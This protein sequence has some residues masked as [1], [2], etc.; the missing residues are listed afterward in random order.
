MPGGMPYHLEKGVTL[1]LIEQHLN[2]K[3]PEMVTKLLA[4]RKEKTPLWVRD[5]APE[6]WQKTA[7]QELR[8]MSGADVRTH[9]FEDWF[10]FKAPAAEGVPTSW[11]ETSRLPGCTGHWI[12]Y[13]GK[14]AEIVRN[15]LIWALELA[16]GIAH[17]A[18]PDTADA[19]APPREIEL[20]WKCPCPWF[21]AW[22]VCRP[23]G[24]VTVFFLTPSHYGSNVAE[25]PLAQ[26]PSA[27]SGAAT[28]SSGHP[29]PNSGRDY[30]Q[31][32]DPPEG[33]AT[34]SL[35]HKRDYATW[36]VTHRNHIATPDLVTTTT[37][38]T[39]TADFAEWGIP[40]LNIY[41]GTEEVVT[42]APSFTAGG[43]TR[44]GKIPNPAPTGG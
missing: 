4:L 41:R 25:S 20:F 11:P 27:V 23:A 5:L 21:E 22:L 44:D 19:S 28:A 15:A 18:H 8:Q 10:G 14:V 1:R 43:V 40:Q 30:E 16:L 31:L 39:T 29:V 42:V 9:I 13:N 17:G 6:L 2:G 34:T 38:T 37:S 26:P 32:I 35:A 3:R 24:P 12:A 36:I 7:F 33:S